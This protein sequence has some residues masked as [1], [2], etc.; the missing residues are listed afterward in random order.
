MIW[1]YMSEWIRWGLRGLIKRI[2]LIIVYGMLMLSH[3][4]LILLNSLIQSKQ[5]ARYSMFRC[6]GH[7]IKMLRV[8]VLCWCFA[9]SIPLGMPLVMESIQCQKIKRNLRVRLLICVPKILYNRYWATSQCGTFNP[10]TPMLLL[11][12]ILELTHLENMMMV[13]VMLLIWILLT[14]I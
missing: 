5:I 6:L 8:G 3:R 4:C 14:H 7:Y 10:C 9:V 13:I 1:I 2:V 12:E 11:R